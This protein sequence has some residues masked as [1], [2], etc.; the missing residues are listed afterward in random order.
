MRARLITATVLAG[1]LA[2]SVSGASAATPT[3]DGAKTKVLTAT[4]TPAAQANDADFVTSA[5]GGPERVECTMPRCARLSFVY[6]PAKGVKATTVGFKVT[7]TLPVEDMDL[8]VAE[9]DKKGNATQIETC[10]T[11]AGTSEQLLLDASTFKAGKTYALI[12]DFYRASGQPVRAEVSFPGT[13]TP[14]SS[15]PAAAEVLPVNCGL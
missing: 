14:K 6:K 3:L 4:Y 9:I 2:A 5:A 10:G 11:F 1:A 7:W 15:V 12:T 8:Y 13:V